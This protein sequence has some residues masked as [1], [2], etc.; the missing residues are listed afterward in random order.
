MGSE[1]KL[2]HLFESKISM[3]EYQFVLM[4]LVTMVVF[5]SNM[6]IKTPTLNYLQTIMSTLKDS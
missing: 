4:V 6:Q 1:I 3:T 2:I 5:L